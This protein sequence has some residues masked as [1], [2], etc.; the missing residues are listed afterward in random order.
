MTGSGRSE[1]SEKLLK[2]SP[3]V[4]FGALPEQG[5][6]PPREPP[7]TASGVAPA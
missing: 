2:T 4:D 1:R 3:P 5:L 7:V 6:R